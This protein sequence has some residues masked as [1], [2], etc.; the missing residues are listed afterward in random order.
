[1]T[2]VWRV[3][4]ASV[5]GTAHVA[6]GRPGQDACRWLVR[7]DGVL[8]AAVADGAGSAERSGEGA[9]LA[10]E[11]AVAHLAAVVRVGTGS[12]G[13]AG[14]AASLPTTSGDWCAVLTAAFDAARNAIIDLAA[15]ESVEPGR[16]ACTLAVVVATP[17]VV[18]AGQ[19][20]DG[21]VVVRELRDD[22]RAVCLPERGDYA[23]ETV[24]LTSDDMAGHRQ[25]HVSEEPFSAIALTTDGLLR[26]AFHVPDHQVHRPFF[27]P[28]FRFAADAVDGAAASTELGAFLTSDRVC[29]R[30]D[31]DKTLILAVLT[32]EAS[33]ERDDAAA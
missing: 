20:G 14:P 30:T 2:A 24:F 3:V 13:D 9:A 11:R 25:C 22:L 32:G 7:D 16:F 8:I 17:T 26:L 6:R 33:S 23:N 12:T 27:D 28:M 10:V 18:A 1:M 31:D 21:L 5:A 19:V 29:A 15:R 4:A